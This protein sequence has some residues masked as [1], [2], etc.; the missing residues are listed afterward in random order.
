MKS[1]RSPNKQ[2]PWS[3]KQLFWEDLDEKLLKSDQILSK[4]AL[5]ENF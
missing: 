3:D 4:V 5:L 1:V 2:N